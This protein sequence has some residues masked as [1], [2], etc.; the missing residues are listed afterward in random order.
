MSLRGRGQYRQNYRG[1]P[2]YVNT[3]RNDYRRQNLEEY[4]ITEVRMF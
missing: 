2:Q 1:R 3:Y 4:K